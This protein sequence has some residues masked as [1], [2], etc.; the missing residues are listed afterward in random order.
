MDEIKPHNRWAPDEKQLVLMDQLA[1]YGL[2]Q[3]QIANC[4]GVSYNTYLDAQKK[5]D[6]LRQRVLSNSEKGTAKVHEAL[7]KL[8][9]SGKCPSATIFWVKC[10][11][12][13]K[14]PAQSLELSGADGG[15][16]EAMLAF[17]EPAERQARIEQKFAKLK[18][19]A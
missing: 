19:L 17:D 5:D 9:I 14:E 15:P 12:R 2:T 11:S 1:H 4:L 13:W 3:P 16:I 8:A 18:L 10:R 7:Y 6:A